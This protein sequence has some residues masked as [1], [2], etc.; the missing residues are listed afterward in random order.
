MAGS[1]SQGIG[2]DE[3]VVDDDLE[4]VRGFNMALKVG[5]SRGELRVR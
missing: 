1:L 4:G 2:G 3:F 5:K